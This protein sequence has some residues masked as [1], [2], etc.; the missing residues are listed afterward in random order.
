MGTR[1]HNAFVCGSLAALVAIASA[2][3]CR[4]ADPTREEPNG[5]APV[6]RSAARRARARV[7][8]V[9]ADAAWSPGP[10][11]ATRLDG[12]CEPGTELL[13]GGW[14]VVA[15]DPEFA[16]PLRDAWQLECEGRS[17]AAVAVL[18]EALAASPRASSLL[19]VR[20]ALYAK[21]GFRRAAERDLQVATWIAPNNARSW[22]GLGQIRQELGLPRSALEA[23]ERSRDLGLVC[24]RIDRS[25]ARALRRLGRRGEAAAAYARV[26][27]EFEVVDPAL[28][29]EAMTLAYDRPISPALL[30]E[31]VRICDAEDSTAARLRDFLR[32]EPPPS[33]PGVNALPGADAADR[34]HRAAFVAHLEREGL[35]A[36]RLAT[37]ARVA[38]VA[39]FLDDPQAEVAPPGDAVAFGPAASD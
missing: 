9:G 16:A 6:D 7:D 17:E 15:F 26:L 10:N 8:A 39:V 30:L 12:G 24:P 34:R 3:G 35:D 14:H 4:G 28:F 36:E 18:N 2:L 38:L 32:D 31:A 23:L 11:A 5:S 21:L 20:G 27:G 13:W 33:V 1:N 29:V 19:E 25:A 37:W 22:C